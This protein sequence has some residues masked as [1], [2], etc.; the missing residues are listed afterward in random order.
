M[1]QGAAE[2][3][4]QQDGRSEA[5]D[6]DR[7]EAR[8]EHAEDAAPEVPAGDEN[9]VAWNS[10]PDE[11]G[12]RSPETVSDDEA[13][14]SAALAEEGSREAEQDLRRAVNTERHPHHGSPPS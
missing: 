12:H 14:V 9:L 8:R 6:E 1:L 3:L 11:A 13:D 4:A 7:S 10:S 2:E 5:R